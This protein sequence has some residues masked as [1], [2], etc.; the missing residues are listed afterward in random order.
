[1]VYLLYLIGLSEVNK[2]SNNLY[3]NDTEGYQCNIHENSYNNP[4]P[5]NSI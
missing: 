5:N 2:I 1:M 3:K 4:W